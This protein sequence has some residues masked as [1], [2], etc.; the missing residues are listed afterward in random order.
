ME[1][2]KWYTRCNGK[3]TCSAQVLISQIPPHQ[4][5]LWRMWEEE[6]KRRTQR[7]PRY[8][9]KG[10]YTSILY[11]A[12]MLPFIAL[13]DV[14]THYITILMHI[15]SYFT[16]FIMKRENAGSWNSGWKRSKRWK[17][18]LH[19]S[20]SPETPQ[21]SF[22]E[23]I[24]NTE[25]RK[26]QRGATSHPQG[27]EVRPTLL[28]TRPDLVGPW[29]ASGAHLWLYGVFHP[30]KNKGETSGSWK[31]GPEKATLGHLFCTTPN[32][33]KLHGDFLWII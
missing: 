8:R 12:F 2:S 6:Y 26:Y 27:W 28:G 11:H 14:I 22:L 1:N 17:P 32:E 10:F 18:I 23:L 9:S 24:K 13:W 3:G 19:N 33:L 5:I 29:Q 15:L 25:W 31:S 21:K 16:R 20:K 7:T 4:L 30:R